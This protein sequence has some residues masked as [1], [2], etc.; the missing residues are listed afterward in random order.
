MPDTGTRASE[1]RT[2]KP[3]IS[4]EQVLRDRGYPREAGA[5]LLDVDGRDV[6]VQASRWRRGRWSV[7][8]LDG[9]F[10]PGESTGDDELDASCIKVALRALRIDTPTFE[11]VD[12]LAS[13]VFALEVRT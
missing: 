2:R 11:Q 6:L 9:R 1:S 4:V 7:A 10:E 13:R 3:S 5:V 12:D 8:S